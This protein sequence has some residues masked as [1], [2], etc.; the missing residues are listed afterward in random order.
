MGGLDAIEMRELNPSTLE[1]PLTTYKASHPI[2]DRI[3]AR[4]I[5]KAEHDAWVRQSGRAYT[6]RYVTAHQG[7]FSLAAGDGVTRKHKASVD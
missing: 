7:D 6:D 2:L 3:P 1:S 5:T 4:G